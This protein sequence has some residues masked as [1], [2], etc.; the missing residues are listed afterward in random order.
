MQVI[1]QKKVNINTARLRRTY[2]ILP[3][4]IRLKIHKATSEPIIDY[5]STV[6]GCFSK[7]IKNLML[8]LE[9]MAA[10][11]ILGN[12]DFINT[13]GK[14]LCEK[15]H[16][17]DFMKRTDFKT[18]ILTYKAIHGLLPDH[19][20]NNITFTHEITNRNTR[21]ASN[22]TLYKP[23]PK[24]EVFKNAFMFRGPFIWNQLPNVLKETSTLNG[25][26]SL[27]KA[28]FLS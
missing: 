17:N 19:L 3:Q 8:R 6:W 7:E 4:N 13:R 14:Q 20:M 5:A 27:Y 9:H 15:L 24:R 11:T 21:S 28:T 10:R 23:L 22:T 12:Y 2:N 1:L 16:I 25:F 18:V 26:K